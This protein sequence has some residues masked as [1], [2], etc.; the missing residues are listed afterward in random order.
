[1]RDFNEVDR[2]KK[3]ARIQ[4]QKN[5]GN[6]SE[7]SLSELESVVRASLKEGYLSC[8]TAWGIA[9]KSN[10]PKTTIGEI[11]DRLGIRITNCQ[12]GCFKIEKT[13][14]DNSSSSNIDGEICNV[15]KELH[16][17]GQLTCAKVFELARQ[18]NLKPMVIA[19]AVNAMGLKIRGCQLGCF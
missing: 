15:L 11:T 4:V 2:E 14:Y 8:P 12:L 13:P 1:M 6:L 17:T 5:P 9:R 10:V 7:E 16:E 3:S 19:D 18:F